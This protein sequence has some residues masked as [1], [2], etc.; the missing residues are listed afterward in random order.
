MASGVF[1]SGMQ[2]V[3]DDDDDDDELHGSV[4]PLHER[5]DDRLSGNDFGNYER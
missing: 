3:Y 5:I 1:Y 2:L 4:M